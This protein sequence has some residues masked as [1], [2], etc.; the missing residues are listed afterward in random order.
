MQF[1]GDYH[2]HT[3][4]SHGKGTIEE[5]VHE[6]ERKGLKQI[7]ISDHGLGHIAFGLRR[8]ELDE[9][10]AKID[11]VN[12]KSTVKTF[13]SVESNMIS[14]EGWVDVNENDLEYFDILLCGYHKFIWP[15]HFFDALNYITYN[16]MY[17]M[18]K[19]EPSKAVVRS[20]TKSYIRAI[21]RYPIDV[22]THV[23]YGLKVNCEEVAKAA[24]DYGTLI[25]INS[26]RISYT[27]EE[28]CKMYDTGVSFI[29]DSDAHTVNRV[30]EFSLAESLIDR[31]KID[32]KRIVNAVGN[33]EEIPF[34]SKISG[35][36]R[37]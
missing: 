12:A 16:G 21:Q 20:N 36:H 5:N 11:A 28:F 24:R 2:T 3:I 4:Y 14:T 1:F 13:M 22:I 17:N 15:K 19:F 33:S 6:A 25:E 31:L 18:F 37:R 30:G 27:D 34:R 35:R 8:R 32:P 29:V 26:K 7:A 10:R 23:N 9:V